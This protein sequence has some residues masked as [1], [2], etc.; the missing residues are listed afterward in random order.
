MAKTINE[1]AEKAWPRHTNDDFEAMTFKASKRKA[2]CQGAN[3]AL[4]EIEQAIKDCDVDGSPYAAVLDR[5]KQLKG[6]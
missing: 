6:E 2:F 3:V 1:I 5:I 4:S